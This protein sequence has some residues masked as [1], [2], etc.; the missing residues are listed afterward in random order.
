M[1]EVR[2]KIIKIRVSDTEL[3]KLHKRKSSARLATWIRNTCLDIE[4]PPAKR[5]RSADPALLKELSKIGSNLNQLAKFVNTH[6]ALPQNFGELL[7]S[8]DNKLTE[9]AKSHDS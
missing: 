3:E 7:Q 9:L 8:I 1:S 2:T 6:D 5:Y 4:P